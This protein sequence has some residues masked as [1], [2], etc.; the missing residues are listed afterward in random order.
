ML[1]N[2]LRKLTIFLIIFTYIMSQDIVGEYKL[3]GLNIVDYDFARQNTDI[4]VTEKSGWDLS[5]RIVYT[6]QQGE[7]IDYD[8]RIPYPLYALT[9]TEVQ[10]NVYFSPDGTATILEGSMYPTE[11]SSDGCFTEE[12]TLPIS[13]DFSYSSDLNSN[14]HIPIIDILGFES[15]SPYRGYPSGSISISGSSVFDF[16]PST[17]TELSMPFPIDTSSVFNNSNGIIPADTILP[18]LTA[19]YVN[20]STQMY[21]FI[22][23]A[24]DCDNMFYGCPPR[25]SLY[26]EWHAIDG[27]VNESGLGDFI[28]QDEDGDG[29][30]FD[31]IYGLDKIKV[32]KV[33]STNE[34]GL[35]S[36]DIAGNHIESLRT[37]KYNQCLNEGTNE[38]SCLDIAD[39]WIDTC[40]DFDDIQDEGNNLYLINLDQDPDF[41]WGGYVTWNSSLYNITQNSNYLID[42]SNENFD[43]NCTE[44]CPQSAT[45]SELLECTEDCSGRLIFEYT[46]QCVP[47]FNMRYFMAELQEQCQEADKDECGV[48]F[49]NGIP[50][51]YCDC[52]FGYK[53]CTGECN[54]PTECLTT[55]CDDWSSD[56][57]CFGCN[58]NSALVEDCAGVCGGDSVYDECG[59][60]G[61]DGIADGACDCDGNV[62]DCDEVCGGDNIVIEPY[63]NCDE[64]ILDECGVCGGGGP[65]TYCFDID[66][67]GIGNENTATLYCYDE[68]PSNWV[69]D[70]SSLEN[71]ESIPHE[72]SISN[73]YPNPFNPTINIEF[74]LSKYSNVD[75]KIY[76]VSGRLV[77]NLIKNNYNTGTHIITW[78][79]SSFSTGIYFVELKSNDKIIT[80]KIE[81]LK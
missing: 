14:Q 5:H 25:P 50:E 13:E 32:T 12:I 52:H 73:I 20:K 38:V 36:Y 34:C 75:I 71:T 49:G 72:I 23:E 56:T 8:P 79:A 80:K 31:T 55:Y 68:V 24:Y 62:Y 17:P 60:C 69:L 35:N 18:G 51:G 57:S 47:S 41:I 2:N 37:V 16:V 1:L 4:V 64:D 39:N 53:D 10:I 33:Y 65:V 48:C 70:C 46:P 54:I 78:D 15:L 77:N 43:S 42:D 76:D 19:G 81:L 28:G 59:V 22:P 30:D 29:T 3:T 21:T 6:I 74:E 44:D 66:G 45:E 27:I 63:C 11:Q 40:I 7:N 58:G 67:D 61:G 9:A 26:L